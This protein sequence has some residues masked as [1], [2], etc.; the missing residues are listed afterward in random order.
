MMPTCHSTVAIIIGFASWATFAAAQSGWQPPPVAAQSGS[1]PPPAAA[2]SG[3]KPPKPQSPSAPPATG[4]P[5]VPGA[6]LPP[7]DYVIGPDDVLGIVFWREK[8]LR[9]T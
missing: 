8:E 6:I 5:A 2:Q 1:Q 4:V 3:S 7:P 9:R